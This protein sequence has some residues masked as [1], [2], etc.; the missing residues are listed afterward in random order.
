M[1]AAHES[2][3]APRPRLARLFVRSWEYRFPRVLWGLRLC[4]GLILEV[5]GLGAGGG[6]RVG[7]RSGHRHVLRMARPG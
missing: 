3:P 1:S 5:A 6:V 7:V 4:G 2:G